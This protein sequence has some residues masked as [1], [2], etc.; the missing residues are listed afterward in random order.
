MRDDGFTLT[1]PPSSC[2]WRYYTQVIA[3]ILFIFASEIVITLR[4]VMLICVVQLADPTLFQDHICDHIGKQD[5]RGIFRKH[6]IGEISCLA[7]IKSYQASG[8]QTPSDPDR[9]PQVV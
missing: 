6:G 2:S 7:R 9:R 5:T 4:H 3:G 8:D 1:S